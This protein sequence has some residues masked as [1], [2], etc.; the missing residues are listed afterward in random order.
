[1]TP[2]TYTVTS[3]VT[4]ERMQD[5][6]CCGL[7]SGDYGDFNI[8][9][10]EAPALTAEFLHLATPLSEHGALLMRDKYGDSDKLHRLDRAAL[11]RGLD[12]MASKYPRLFADFL[13][14]NEDVITGTAFLQC[15]LLGEIVYG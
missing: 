4:P 2:F 5:L 6:L 8:A 15:C 11:Q 7:E 10:Y 12:V 9:G 3:E 1:M 13:Q 14:E